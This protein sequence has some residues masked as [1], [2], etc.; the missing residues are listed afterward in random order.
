MLV[1]DDMS[2]SEVMELLAPAEK[3]WA[4]RLTRLYNT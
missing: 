1:G 2:Y 4:G 3:N